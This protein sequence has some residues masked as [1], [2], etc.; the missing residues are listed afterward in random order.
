MDG[1]SG[2]PGNVEAVDITPYVG[3]PAQVRGK[4]LHERIVVSGDP[5]TTYFGSSADDLEQAAVYR[6]S[7]AIPLGGIGFHDRRS[8]PGNQFSRKFCIVHGIGPT[9]VIEGRK[10]PVGG[11]ARVVCFSVVNVGER[12]GARHEE[13]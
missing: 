4:P 9:G 13:G 3:T 6:H 10:H 5:V 1:V 11:N 7:E 12:H 2:R 8:I